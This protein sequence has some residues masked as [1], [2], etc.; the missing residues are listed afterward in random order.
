MARWSS[1]ASELPRSAGRHRLRPE[2]LS[3]RAGSPSHSW[4]LRPGLLTASP[5][6]RTALILLTGVPAGVLTLWLVA[7]ARA[8]SGWPAAL[9]LMAVSLLIWC[10]RVLPRWR[11]A[12]HEAPGESAHTLSW[13]GP[14]PGQVP[15][16][17][18]HQPEATPEPL[19]FTWGPGHHPVQPSLKLHWG[20]HL[21]LEL[22]DQG[23]CWAH[24]GKGSG[25][26]ALKVLLRS[27]STTAK[28][29]LRPATGPAGV[30]PSG[31]DVDAVASCASWSSA[32][33]RR[34]LALQAGGG[35]GHPDVDEV[36]AEAFP[37]TLI[38]HNDTGA[39]LEPS[40]AHGPARP[41][42]WT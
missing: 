24:L 30:R 36:D 34:K 9:L 2:S 7:W 20:D 10:V 4:Q 6:P 32:V 41:P 14:M 17:T 1:S 13:W 25:Q 22:P 23:W 39:E 18:R 37:A 29:L 11:A 27:A 35:T 5:W 42:R 16:R 31:P 15:E 21:C 12:T 28:P 38:M 33:A 26:Q 8:L 40:T 19:G 3:P